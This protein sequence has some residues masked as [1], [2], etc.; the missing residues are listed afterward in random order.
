MS[1][2]IFVDTSLTA[3]DFRWP[4]E[5]L[6]ATTAGVEIRE[7]GGEGRQAGRVQIEARGEGMGRDGRRVV[8]ASSGL[9]IH[10]Q[11]LFIDQ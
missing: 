5:P 8:D 4:G 10:S 2:V 6:R 1:P 7:G 11:S 3:V 9:Q